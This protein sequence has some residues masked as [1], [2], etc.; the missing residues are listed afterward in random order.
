MSNRYYFEYLKCP[1]FGFYF[2]F[3]FFDEI[4]AEVDEL[5]NATEYEM[6]RGKYISY[7]CPILSQSILLGAVVLS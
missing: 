6:G 4:L 3:F 7:F 5:A 2:I 1:V